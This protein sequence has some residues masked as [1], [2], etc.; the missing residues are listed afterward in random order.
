MRLPQAPMRH[1][2]VC[3][4]L[5]LSVLEAGLVACGAPGSAVAVGPPVF[6]LNFHH[7]EQG[8]SDQRPGD[9][10]LSEF[11]AMTKVVWR[12]WGPTRA[13]GSGK[14]T[15]V[16]CLPHCASRPYDATVTLSNVL[17]VRGK[18]YFTRYRVVADIPEEERRQADLAG[19]LP[20]P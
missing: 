6:V 16:W 20:T 14:L 11:S 17:A 15:G 1:V 5:A 9:L 3:F 19:V 12:T 13:T 4:V 7:A 10:V 8:R 18:G 2:F